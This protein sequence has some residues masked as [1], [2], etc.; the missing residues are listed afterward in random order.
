MADLTSGKFAL[1]FNNG[2]LEQ[3]LDNGATWTAISGGGGTCPLTLVQT[4]VIAVATNTITFSGLSGDTDGIYEFRFDCLAGVGATAGGQVVLTPNGITTNQ[5]F[6]LE[7]LQGV[8]ATPTPAYFGG[9]A[10]MTVAL[11]AKAGDTWTVSGTMYPKTGLHRTVQTDW[12]AFDSSA[13]APVHVGFGAAYWYETV[14][15]ITS[16]TFAHATQNVFGANSICS[17]WRRGT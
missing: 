3:T 12:T 1:R 11:S 17:L 16:L 13:G 15:A 9:A 10:P 7:Y 5:Y 14:T 8:S 4:Q 2:Q 6:Q